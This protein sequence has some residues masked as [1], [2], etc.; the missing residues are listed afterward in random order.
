MKMAMPWEF[1]L[2]SKGKG[3]LDEEE[4]GSEGFAA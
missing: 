1:V 2:L 3:N 4:S